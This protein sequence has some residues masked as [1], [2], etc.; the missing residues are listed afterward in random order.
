M[1][2]LFGF[3]NNG[4]AEYLL[5]ISKRGPLIRGLRVFDPYN[6][7][8]AITNTLIDVPESVLLSHSCEN[9]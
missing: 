3:C 8:L 1:H 9:M 7:T 4:N 5:A 2:E 6:K